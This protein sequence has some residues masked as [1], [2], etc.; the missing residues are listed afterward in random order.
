MSDERECAF[1]VS[2]WTHD[3]KRVPEVPNW[4]PEHWDY[5]MRRL[6]YGD[7]MLLA[8]WKMWEARW[9]KYDYVKLEWRSTD[10]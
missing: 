4:C 2:V 1:E 10:D 9:K 7:N 6:Y 8:L 3:G 5:K